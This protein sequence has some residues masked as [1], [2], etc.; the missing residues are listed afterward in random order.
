MDGAGTY[1]HQQAI[2]GAAQD[3]AHLMPVR[4]Y[5][6]RHIDGAGVL[7]QQVGRGG[8]R[9]DREGVHYRIQNCHLDYLAVP[10]G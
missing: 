3:L 5:L 4:F 6:L 8:E 9:L 10:G 2:I 7:C 1:H